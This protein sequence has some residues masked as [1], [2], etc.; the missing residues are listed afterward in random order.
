MIIWVYGEDTFRSRQKLKELIAGFKNKFDAGGLNLIFFKE[1]FSVD[2]L[3]P[4]VASMPFM[5]PKKMII[6]ENIS[7][8]IK[9]KEWG[10]YKDFWKSVPEETILVLWEE[11]SHSD[12]D[13]AFKSMPKDNLYYY[14]Y[15]P[16]SPAELRQW[17]SRQVKIKNLKIEA[18]VLNSLI[19]KIG[20]D[21]WRLD[22]ELDKLKARANGAEIKPEYIQELVDTRLEDNVFLF[23]DYL[24]QR[25]VA[26]AEEILEKLIKSGFNEI[27]L[28]GKLIWQLR[29]MLKLKSYIDE[30]PGASIN[31]AAKELG[32][33][34]YVAKKTNPLLSKFKP[35][36][37]KK[38]YQKA[39]ELEAGLKTGK[40]DSRLG[41]E[42]L[43]AQI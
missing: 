23:C 17:L 26:L 8:S 34:P 1:N 21:T 35:S 41:L 18:R 15:P 36:D 37:L 30:S 22:S 29:V 38:I 6:I 16:L 27:E 25:K 40:V 10:E 9:A 42:L 3:M 5:A 4:A 14:D 19:D 24:A 39:L 13:K 2:E 11:A 43:V 12:L 33:H 31:Q 7:K 20:Q 28:L 32:L